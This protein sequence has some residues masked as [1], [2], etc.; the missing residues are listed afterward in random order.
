VLQNH[1]LQYAAAAVSSAGTTTS[2]NGPESKQRVGSGVGATV[3]AG[4]G[5]LV[6]L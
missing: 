4:V 1:S 2:Q 5:L 6:G 3:G